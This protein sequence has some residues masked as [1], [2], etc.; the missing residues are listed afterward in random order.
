MVEKESVK[1]INWT[2][3]NIV[4]PLNDQA[5]RIFGK[6]LTPIASVTISMITPLVEKANFKRNEYTW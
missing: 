1:S 4:K 5:D 2:I 6:D 3:I